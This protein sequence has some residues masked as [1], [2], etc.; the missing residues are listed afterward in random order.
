MRPPHLATIRRVQCANVC[1]IVIAV[2]PLGRA[3]VLAAIWG[4]SSYCL[5]HLGAQVAGAT[6]ASGA[7][8]AAVPALLGAAT[9][10]VS[11]QGAALVL[12]S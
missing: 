11:V 5:L 3:A 9:A 6:G 12:L 10:C 2:G 1:Q 8:E 7:I 4:A